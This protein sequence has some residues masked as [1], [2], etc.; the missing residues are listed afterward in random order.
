PR[1]PPPRLPPIDLRVHLPTPVHVVKAPLDIMARGELLVTVR[2]EGIVTRGVVEMPSG[3]IS[4]FGYDHPLVDG[5]MTFDEHHPGGRLDLHFERPLPDAA[6]RDRADP[7]V[8]ERISVTGDPAKPTVVFSGAANATLPEVFAVYNAGR[9]VYAP[10][11]GVPASTMAQTPR[12][13]QINIL[14]YVSLALP[15]L[16][17]LDRAS[18]WSDANEPRGAYGR[19][20][21]LE[22]ERAT[23]DETT[24]V[25]AV[26]RPTTPGRSTGEVQLDH[27]FVHDARA[28]FGIGLRVGD[29]LG[30]GL[31][32]FFDWTSAR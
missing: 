13:D 6:L 25:R 18:A 3:S 10:R 2:P 8:G 26:G 15:H 17:F 9:S 31:G 27:L 22:L 11:P 32:L 29:R 23:S 24:R 12:G 7:R 1:R 30:G 5:R 4:L 16:L 20:R 21:N 14:A 19:I 28:A